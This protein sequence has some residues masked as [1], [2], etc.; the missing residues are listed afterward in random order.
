[1]T[2][3]ALQ[4][5]THVEKQS[6]FRS[7]AQKVVAYFGYNALLPQALRS[8]GLEALGYFEKLPTAIGLRSQL[9]YTVVSE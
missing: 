4:A 6:K 8:T 7:N 2:R 5:R 1:M 3:L 9:L